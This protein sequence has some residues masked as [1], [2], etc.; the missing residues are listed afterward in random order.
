MTTFNDLQDLWHNQPAA[1]QV[2]LPDTV[3][4]QSEKYIRLIRRTQRFTMF[5]LL[6]TVSGLVLY[7]KRY[8]HGGFSGFNIGL[9]MMIGAL[10]LRSI[11]ELVNFLQLQKVQVT[12]GFQLYRE[13][14]LRF[15]ERRRMIHLLVTP[16]T[17][18][19]YITGFVLLLPVFRTV[20]STGFYWYLVVS[21]SLFFLVFS[22]MLFRTIRKEMQWLRFLQQVGHTQ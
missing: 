18:L 19:L 5:I 8:S 15:Y 2:P 10:L 1:K 9:C 4:A 12:A 17:M 6:L 21:G 11:T 20:F 14:M 16:V 3:I 7:F 13:R 22:F